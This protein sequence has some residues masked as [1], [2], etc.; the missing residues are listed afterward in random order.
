MSYTRDQL[1]SLRSADLR[2]S[3]CVRKRLFYFRLWLPR[4]FRP[5][6]YKVNK[7]NH[8]VPECSSESNTSSPHGPTLRNDNNQFTGANLNSQSVG[9]KSAV[10]VD[11]IN[12]HKLDVLAITE[13]HHEARNDI[14]I[15]RITPAG[16]CSV[17]LPRRHPGSQST[18]AS[19]HRGGGVALVYRD[20]IMAKLISFDFAPTTF[21]VM[22]VNLNIA[23]KNVIILV[24][25]RPGS[26]TIR[27][28]FF[29][30]LSTVL[31]K[32][33]NYNC[34]IVITGDL[35]FHLD[36]QD[37]SNSIQL[38]E[39]L[40]SFGLSQS[41]S[42][43]THRGG[44]T[45]DVVIT[46]SDLPSPIIHIDPQRISDHHAVLFQLDIQRPPIR[47]V[48]VST[49]AWKKFDAVGF[50]NDL[51]ASD[52]CLPSER[53][54]DQSIDELQACY[55]S[56]LSRLL[57][58]Y[59]PKCRV[60]RRYQPLTPWFDADCLASRRK[61]RLL[62]RRY[63]RT[64]TA[65]D[66][67]QWITQVRLMHKL[68]SDKQTSYWMNKVSDSQGCPKKLWKTLS[69]V[70]GRD[71]HRRSKH[72]DITADAFSKAFKAKVENIRQ[73][74]SSAE[75][76]NFRDIKCSSV[77]CEFRQLTVA[78]TLRL[79][80][81]A[82]N[83]NCALDPVPTWIVK[84]YADV[85]APFV[86]T[87]LNSSIMT[88]KFPSSQKCAIV[89]PLLKKESL[90]P[91]DLGNYR[92]VSNLS[93]LSKVLERAVYEQI[94]D[95]LRTYNL[96]P[97]YQSAYRSNHSTETVLL[98]VMSDIYAASD[99]KKLTLLALLDQ[100]AAFDVVDHSIL[101]KRLEFMFGLKGVAL[102][103]IASYLTGRKQ[104]VYFN[105]MSEITEV[106]FGVPQ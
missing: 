9:N 91:S 56:T 101:L 60:R 48:D 79:L 27:K 105:G 31:E 38:N 96:L 16:Y 64:G 58:K 42:G 10:I 86:T 73:T 78:D 87:L 97:K 32:V 59:A 19:Y 72:T 92:P 11:F 45:L 55:D 94:I 71:R 66:R 20:N 106:M 25:Y 17:D 103:W 76:P 34:Q 36:V 21:E 35:N 15:R 102:E 68:Y 12:V 46:R 2:I 8:V 99:S 40:Q 51:L 67:A 93:F 53:Y 100:S 47:W 52:L 80:Q 14:Y 7:Y 54:D 88:G 90:D 61:A 43:P 37:D 30:E 82:N 28:T 1:L 77:F 65:A 75:E 69:G 84:Q 62:E 104:Y 41:V 81:R 6:Y 29:S 13:T 95:Y 49:R 98:D 74:T 50:R 44:H 63:R 18:D 57:D 85:L 22:A 39:L 5:R 4:R 33:S 70:L 24:I 26:E 89:T 3:R 23:R 83:K